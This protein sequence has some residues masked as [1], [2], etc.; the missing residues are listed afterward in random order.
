[1][2]YG[3]EGFKTKKD[4]RTAVQTD[5]SEVFVFGTSLFGDE[6]SGSVEEVLQVRSSI[7]VVG[8]DV[9]RDRRWYA[10]VDRGKDGKVRVR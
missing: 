7:I 4:L 6:P 5:P 2:S 10:N 8:P 3:V 1:M 9:Y